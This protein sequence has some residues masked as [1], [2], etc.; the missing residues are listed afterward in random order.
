MGAEYI[1]SCYQI[2]DFL[3]YYIDYDKFGSDLVR[4][5]DKYYELD[6]GRIV[7]MNY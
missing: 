3:E 5:D 1:E 6:D 2:P 4:D 7:E